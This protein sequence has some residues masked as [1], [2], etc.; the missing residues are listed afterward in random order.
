MNDFGYGGVEASSP[1]WGDLDPKKDKARPKH[2]AASSKDGATHKSPQRF[3][4]D[5]AAT[6]HFERR[7]LGIGLGFACE[8][9]DII[10]RTELT[11]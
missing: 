8:R 9:G 3:D 2:K 7:M 11:Q 5:H 10:S 4:L 6:C 1:G